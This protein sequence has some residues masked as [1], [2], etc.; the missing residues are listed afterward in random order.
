MLPPAVVLLPLLRLKRACTDA[1][2]VAPCVEQERAEEGDAGG[3]A[4]SMDRREKVAAACTAAV[5]VAAFA[6]WL[7]VRKSDRV[8]GNRPAWPVPGVEQGPPLFK[9][10]GPF[11]VHDANRQ[12][13]G[14]YPAPV[15]NSWYHVLD[16]HEVVAGAKPIHVRALGQDLAVWRTSEGRP[17]V[18][19]AFCAHLGAN[20]AEPSQHLL[21]NPGGKPVGDCIE[22]PFH[23]WRFDADGKLVD[24]PYLKEGE[25]LP[26]GQTRVRTYPCKDWCGMLVMYF[27]ADHEAD[28]EPEFPLPWWID[29]QLKGNGGG[30]D[31]D[32]SPFSI[33]KR[34]D[35]G[36]V[37]L[38]PC[39]WVDQAGDH[40]H[41]NSLH[42]R[43]TIPYTLFY[44]PLSLM[45]CRH[46]AVTYVGDKAGEVL[47][48]L[49]KYIG[50]QMLNP[51]YI[52]FTD[53]AMPSLGGGRYP[54]P[55]AAT[56]EMYIGPA[57]MC[58]HIPLGDDGMALKLFVTTTPVLGGSVL[59]V[60]AWFNRRNPLWRMVAWGAAGMSASQL[61]ADL[62]I[63]QHRYRPHKPNITKHCGPYSTTNRWLKQFYSKSSGS[64]TTGGV[65]PEW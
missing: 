65:F 39:D 16:S 56:L 41:F 29:D 58:F 22:C 24:V 36:H 55:H 63:I 62:E 42:N 60:R 31:A 12:K 3:E 13:S 43:M 25:C 34:W 32:K 1:C 40:A 27:H 10:L 53:L 19:S 4:R 20:M 44:L 7:R 61:M 28:S 59:R 17:V 18:M 26:Q 47:Q 11:S 15:P 37:R 52:Y 57:M 51:N 35:V 54:I 45:E 46:E 5:G 21:R 64:F 2:K 6:L 49:G 33:L 8:A 30:A 23:S 14:A 38:S 9:S 48:Q 50:P